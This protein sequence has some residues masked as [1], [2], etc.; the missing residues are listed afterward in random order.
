MADIVFDNSGYELFTDLCLADFIV[1]M[2]FAKSIRF[3][4]KMIPWFLSDVMSKDFNW[5]LQQM[6]T[7]TDESLRQLGGR[8]NNYV[9]EK[10]WTI[11]EDEFWT[12]PVPFSS[13]ASVKPD[14]YAKLGEAKLIIFKGKYLP[15]LLQSKLV[16]LFSGDMNYRKLF[17]E[18]NWDPTTPV[19]VALEGFNPSKLVTLRTVKA[20]IICGLKP[21]IAEERT[22]EEPEWMR[23]GKW[24]LIQFSDKSGY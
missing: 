4:V 15:T 10:T 16:L 23:T 11:I 8:W 17:G 20:D 1:S 24:S 13:M 7:S 12:Y 22:A 6:L 21:G 3:Y 18:K 14:L 19:D 2:G 9:N 5:T